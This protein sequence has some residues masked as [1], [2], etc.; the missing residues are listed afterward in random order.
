MSETIKRAFITG[1]AGGLGSSF[2]NHLAK[3]GW[4]LGL[5]DIRPDAL[6]ETAAAL[7]KEFGKRP[8]VYAFDITN[9]EAYKEAVESFMQGG[10]IDLLINNAGVGDGGMLREYS[11]ENFQWVHETNFLSV[12]YGCKLFLPYFEAQKRGIILNIASAAAFANGPGM[13]AYN[14][15]KAAVRSLSETLGYELAPFNVQ[16]SVAMPTFFRT[17]VMRFARGPESAQSFAQKMIE[18]SGLQAEHIAK[19]I[20]EKT[21][22]GRREIIL[23]AKA[24]M[25]YRMKRYLPFIFSPK[26][27][28]KYAQ[29]T[30]KKIK[31]RSSA[32]R[33]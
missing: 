27:R 7:E 3:A 17:G 2:A 20:L 1:G 25:V 30:Q 15:A 6:Q 29:G 16:V 28:R 11:L 19:K 32:I 21:F 33:I 31:G 10:S 12:A 18:S 8:Q 13:T 4:E 14:S 9:R 22:A 5:T 23:P 24:R 26:G